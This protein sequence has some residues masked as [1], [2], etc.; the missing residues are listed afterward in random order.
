MQEQMELALIENV[1]RVDLSPLEQAISIARLH[2]Q[3]SLSYEEISKRL[4]KANSTVNNL[5]RLLQLPEDARAALEKGQISEGHARSILAAK[6]PVQQKQLLNSIVQHGWS[7]RQ[8]ERYVSSLKAGAPDAKT[9][10]KHV[11]T[12]TPV[13]KAL[14]KQLGS[15]VAIRRTAKGGRLELSFKNEY[16][17]T[18]LL[19]LLAKLK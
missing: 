2:E 11:D 10:K 18:R 4:G 15:P 16:D 12:E 6:D 3:F 17:L 13:T 14:S 9:A 1:Q 5:V 8:A 19:D 7:V